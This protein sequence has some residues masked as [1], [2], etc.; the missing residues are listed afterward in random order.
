MTDEFEHRH[1]FPAGAN[2]VRQSD[3]GDRAAVDTLARL[4]LA[5]ADLVT[6]YHHI[7]DVTWPD[8]GNGYFID[9][10]RDVLVMLK[11]HGTM[12]LGADQSGRGLVIGSNGGGLSYVVA[13]SGAIYRTRAASLH[14]PELEKVADDL[15]HFL[16]LLEQSLNQFLTDGGTGCV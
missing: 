12:E 5:P 9:P 8:V 11:E 6:F 3:H 16:E 2:H 4:N 1:G 15:R 7:R 10:V 14:E 13:P